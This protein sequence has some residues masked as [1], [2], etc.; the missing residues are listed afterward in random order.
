MEWSGK[1]QALKGQGGVSAS[2]RPAEDREELWTSLQHGR[3]FRK[4]LSLTFRLCS[5][6]MIYFN[7]YQEAML[8]VVGGIS[9]AGEKLFEDCGKSVCCVLQESSEGDPGGRSEARWDGEGHTGSSA[10]LTALSSNHP[11]VLHQLSGK[12]CFLHHHR[13][14]RGNLAFSGGEWEGLRIT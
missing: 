5:S 3:D 12:R 1:C 10:S 13:V 4:H 14:L 11:Q 6:Q 7:L 8:L 2:Q 9:R